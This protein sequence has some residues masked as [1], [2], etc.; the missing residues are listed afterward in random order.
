M[1]DSLDGLRA[2][3]VGEWNNHL[4][5]Y[6]VKFPQSDSRL[7]QLLCLYEFYPNPVSQNEMDEWIRSRGGKNNRQARHLAWDGWYIQTGNSKSTRMEISTILRNDQLK[8][9][10]L[11]EPNPIWLRFNE[12]QERIKQLYPNFDKVV[13]IFS[14]RGCAMCGF[15]PL[16]L[17]PYSK[18][19]IETDEF[20]II[21]LCEECNDWC[22]NR[23]IIL[24][25]SDILVARPLINFEK[26]KEQRSISAMKGVETRRLKKEKRSV[27]AKKGAQT[28][29]INSRKAKT[30]CGHTIKVTAV[31]K[32]GGPK[33]GQW[34]ILV[35]GPKVSGKSGK[36][37][38]YCN[39]SIVHVRQKLTLFLGYCE[40]INPKSG[41]P[42]ILPDHNSDE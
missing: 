29:W 19:K 35:R 4:K 23:N 16:Y 32:K 37:T 21:P 5:S 36:K 3:L 33:Q 2:R 14:K 40:I 24:E 39:P 31:K 8:L 1:V 28:R 42:G 6:D 10:S 15:K 27:S 25:I 20:D 11:E 17:Y 7:L 12:E 9:V 26:T 38:L 41:L 34:S 30:K 13:S 22:N 18:I